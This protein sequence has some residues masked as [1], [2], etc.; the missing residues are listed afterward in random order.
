MATNRLI[1]DLDRQF[2]D[3]LFGNLQ[4]LLQDVRRQAEAIRADQSRTS[5]WKARQLAALQSAAKG[6]LSSWLDHLAEIQGQLGD[7]D[8][9]YQLPQ[10]PLEMARLTFL[11]DMLA[12]SGRPWAEI[13]QQA[14]EDILRAV[15]LLRPVLR[16]LGIW[17]DAFEAQIRARRLQIDDAFKALEERR[18]ALKR[19]VAIAANNLHQA[20]TAIDEL[21]DRGI[22][23]VDPKTTKLITIG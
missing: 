7:L 6:R 20:M 9:A 21:M 19:Q 4:S 17:T 8:P 3:N 10:D 23:L 1:S 15:Y 11:A 13:I 18:Q 22:T 16:I 14:D 12:K 2:L 5:E